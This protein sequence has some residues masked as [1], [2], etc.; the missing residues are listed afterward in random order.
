MEKHL[1]FRPIP[2]FQ[3]LALLHFKYAVVLDILGM[4]G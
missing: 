1:S 2:N 4:Y 3:F